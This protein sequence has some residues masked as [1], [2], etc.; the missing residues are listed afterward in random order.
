VKRKTVEELMV[1]VSEYATVSQDA[2]L[3][4]AVLELEKA[5]KKFDKHEYLHRAVLIYNEN[6]FIVGKVSQL[7]ILRALEPKYDNIMDSNFSRYGFT[8]KF[9][10][11]MLENFDLWETSVE[12]LA[13][14]ASNLK[15][16]DFMYTP[17]E[18]EFVN[19]KATLDEATHQIVMGHHQSLLVISSKQ[20]IGVLRL[21]DVFKEICSAIK[22]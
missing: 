4:D 5:Q 14:K 1:P 13:K 21:T 9:M 7:D 20:I 16:K 10:R 12:Q 8:P 18:G 19:V 11:S 2:T 22:S 3:K 17:S 15:I 6:N